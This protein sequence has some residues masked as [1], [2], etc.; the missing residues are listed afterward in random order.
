[1]VK[2][3]Q[4]NLDKRLLS[5]YRVLDLTNEWGMMCGKI[6][7]DLGAD[8]IKIE[9]PGGD[10]VRNIGPFYHDIPHP[11]KSLFWLACNTNKRGIT[12]DIETSDGK[13]LF[14]ELV[15]SADIITESYESDYLSRIGL[16]YE[17]LSEINT[18]I[19]MT[20]ITAFGKTGPYANLKVSDIVAFAMGG[21]MSQC[22]DPDRPPVHVGSPQS[23]MHAGTDG[24]EGT[25]LA[26]YHR[27]LTGE[28]QHVDVSSQEGLMWSTSENMIE[29]DILKLSAKRPGHEIKRP[30]GLHCPVIWKCKD[31]YV[32]MM[33]MGG[34]PGA[35]T[36]RR[37]TEWMDSEGMAPE[38]LKN[39]DWE[40]WDWQTLTQEELDYV[41]ASVARL[42]KVHTKAEI[43]EEAIKRVIQLGPVRN[44]EETVT[45]PQLNY[46]KFLVDIEHDELNDTITYPGAF[47]KFSETPIEN[48]RRAPLIGEHNKEIFINELKLSREEFILLKGRGVI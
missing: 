9:K 35:K 25:M 20:S 17:G 37:L 27:Q 4:N 26:L 32:A 14:K 13:K 24:A 2:D 40:N 39:K 22:G 1:M 16:S 10:P 28:G 33:L 45:N 12:L 19:I 5:P 47:A 34:Q 31:G 29:W 43:Q 44:A 42:F 3:Q 30:T 41:V 38:D 23:F 8:V 15:K 11:E 6:L 7:A 46:R 36:N 21:L 48:W 18:Q